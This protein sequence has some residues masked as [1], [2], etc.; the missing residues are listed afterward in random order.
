MPTRNEK[1]ASRLNARIAGILYL[2][3]VASSV[4]ALSSTTSLIV[5]GDAAATA[6][7]LLK[8][9]QAFRLAFAANLVAAA[10]YVGVVAILYE[11]F[12]PV[13]RTLSFVAAAFGLAGCAISG[14]VMVNQLAPLSYLGGDAFLAPLGEAQRQALAYVPLR[15]IGIGT[16]VSLVFFGVYCILVGFL[17]FRSAFLPRL[18]GTLML[19]A[20]LGWLTG[21][22][23]TFLAPATGGAISSILLPVSGLCETLFALWLALV[24]VNAAKWREQAGAM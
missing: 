21:S 24:S 4:F 7:N 15:L 1:A 17:V 12:R 18:L 6:A 2:V 11:V 13:S 20:G 5:R 9:E 22:F 16:D 10:A 3:V 8:S 23:A 19:V 14:A